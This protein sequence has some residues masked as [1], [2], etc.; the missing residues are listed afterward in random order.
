MDSE[1]RTT[2]AEQREKGREAILKDRTME[3][4]RTQWAVQLT[5]PDQLRLNKEKA[6][7][8][9]GPTQLVARVEAVGLC[10]SDLKLLK[11][12]AGHARKSEVVGG[13]GAEVLAE[14]PSYVPGD[15]ATVPGHEVVA[16]IVAVGKEVRHHRLGERVMVQADWRF[17]KTAQ[18]NGSF[19]YDFEGGLQE[20]VLLDERIV[21]E[22]GTGERYLLAVGE[23]CGASAL[24][25]VEPWAC[26]E[27]SY[28]SR[29]RRAI[30]AGGELLVVV[31]EGCEVRGLK[32]SLGAEG[33]PTSVTVV[34]GK[35]SRTRECGELGAN[36]LEAGE[37]A[38]LAERGFDDIVYFGAQAER[39]EE[40]GEKL[41]VGGVFNMVQCG[42]RF[43][44]GVSIDVGRVHYGGTR[45]CGTT[46]GDASESYRGIPENGET[47]DGERMLV[48]GAGGPM[49]QMHVVRCLCSGARGV[50]LVA[51]D[52]DTPRLEGLGAKVR[53]LAERQRVKLTLA[54][55]KE[56]S[57]GEE[58]TYIVLMAPI[59]GLV[60]QAV[61]QSR[62]G[63]RINI[64]AGIPAGT[65]ATLDLDGYVAKRLW[66][67]G[68]SGSTI[69]D[70]KL[71][72]AKVES[73]ELDTNYSVGAVSGMTGA[74]DGIR[75]TENRTVGG[76]IIVYP[77]LHEM[78]LVRMEELG[79]RYP[80]VG[81]KL[82]EGTWTKE[83]EEEMM[84]K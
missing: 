46:G 66:M 19:G 65:R 18:S 51:S 55:A 72:L 9:P 26:V 6:V 44:R 62:E 47:R 27:H 1:K 49:G 76:K 60:T 84:K 16:R 25:L 63:G 37:V 45:W 17:L 61:G 57:W 71:V 80:S 34:G 5:G 30:K 58:F 41:A 83:A 14:N 59:A 52:V 22:P 69:G 15:K 7:F 11:Q 3:L 54:N 75:A 53:G 23:K 32:G 24:A 82:R 68:T 56:T 64:F 73:G 35:G 8:R 13:I 43:G 74:I 70:M 78:G 38:G 36:V 20:Y 67:F 40:L 39:V 31:E 12:F 50:T 42:G 48:V 21:I 79:G 2:Q 81:A 4:P 77:G 33:K 29:E 28:V 10:F